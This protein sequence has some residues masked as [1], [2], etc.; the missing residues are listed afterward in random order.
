MSRRIDLL[1]QASRIIR[2]KDPSS[3]IKFEPNRRQRKPRTQ[4]EWAHYFNRKGSRLVLTLDMSTEATEFRNQ[5][6]NKYLHPWGAFS[7][8]RFDLIDPLPQ[9][10]FYLK[11]YKDVI[12]DFCTKGP[13]PL[14]VGPTMNTF[15]SEKD[16]I[17]G[18]VEKDFPNGYG[19]GMDSYKQPPK[20]PTIRHFL[21]SLGLSKG[22]V[23][24]RLREYFLKEFGKFPNEEVQTSMELLSKEKY[25][26]R[27]PLG[28]SKDL[29]AKHADQARQST[30]EKFKEVGG[31]HLGNAVGL[32]L[33]L[34]HYDV[35]PMKKWHDPILVGKKC[36]YSRVFDG[37]PKQQP[38]LVSI[39]PEEMPEKSPEDLDTQPELQWSG[40]DEDVHGEG[41]RRV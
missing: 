3:I 35:N 33:W 4:A 10:D 21:I 7:D 34:R 29:G 12:N 41:R 13:P 37:I 18:L 25:K 2:Q 17:S 36:L 40:S 30:M 19:M 31:I 23:M 38:S 26:A 5:L 11:M 9:R 14:P 27:M 15:V 28:F 32:S 22:S 39:L 8:T 20:E 24:H 16:I 6:K 1:S